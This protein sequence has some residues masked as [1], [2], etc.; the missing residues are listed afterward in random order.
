MP[1]I[2]TINSNRYEELVASILEYRSLTYDEKTESYSATFQFNGKEDAGEEL[3][4][5]SIYQDENANLVVYGYTNDGKAFEKVTLDGAVSQEL[6][7]CEF[8]KM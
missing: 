5:V 3:K 7:S 6:C 4:N 2:E 8:F 1:F